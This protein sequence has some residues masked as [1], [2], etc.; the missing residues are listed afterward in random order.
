VALVLSHS[1]AVGELAETAPFEGQ[2]PVSSVA[3]PVQARALKAFGTATVVDESYGGDLLAN[4][5]FS[6]ASCLS[7]ISAIRQAQPR[8]TV[9]F[10]ARMLNDFYH[11]GVTFNECLPEYEQNLVYLFAAWQKEYPGVPL[12]VGSDIRQSAAHEDATD[13]C[14]PAL[15][16]ADWRAGIESTV[17]DYATSND[18]A[19]LHFVDMSEWVPQSDLL[20]G[21]IHPSTAGQV[22]ICQAVAGLFHQ[23]VKCTVP[24]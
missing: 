4:D 20:S 5:C 24:Q 7:Y 9:G 14:T 10:V 2:G 1:V 17:N 12:Y 23:P 8:V 19:W 22:K 15:K 16:L 21:G 3:W 13:G 11:G 6:Q 18:A